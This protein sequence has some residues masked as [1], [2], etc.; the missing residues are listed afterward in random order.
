MRTYENKSRSGK[1]KR[2][3]MKKKEIFSF[4]HSEITKDCFD[5]C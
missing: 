3:T 1:I 2:E 5:I 4:I